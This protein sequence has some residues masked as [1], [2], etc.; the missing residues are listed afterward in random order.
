MSVGCAAGTKGGNGSSSSSSSGA[1]S[2]PIIVKAGAAKGGAR[3]RAL[4]LAR[5]R[6]ARRAWPLT[7]R[8]VRR[9]PL[10]SWSGFLMPLRWFLYDWLCAVW[11]VDL[12][13]AADFLDCGGTRH[14]GRAEVSVG[15]RGGRARGGSVRRRRS[16][17]QAG[18]RGAREGGEGN[19]VLHLF[20][21]FTGASQP[22]LE[23]ESM[24][25][26]AKPPPTHPQ[27]GGH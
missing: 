2:S 19:H 11:L 4:Q 25:A 6:A 5:Q 18:R 17:R 24:A 21:S 10:R 26:G 27:E 13:M 1:E 12:A 7:P 22:H 15:A 8:S 16:R 23:R 3:R 14:R 9:W 20:A